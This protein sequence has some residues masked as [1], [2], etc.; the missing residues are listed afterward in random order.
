MTHEPARVFIVD[1][2]AVQLLVLGRILRTA[3]HETER[4]RACS[5]T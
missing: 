3:G 5:N 2:D 4:A 1:D